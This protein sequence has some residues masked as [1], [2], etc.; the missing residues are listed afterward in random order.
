[1]VEI[2]QEKFI[3]LLA[4]QHILTG[5]H[6][7]DSQ[8]LKEKELKLKECNKR[9]VYIENLTKAEIATEQEMI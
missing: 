1:M 7:I 3:D 9:G 5:D 8:I 4:M 2:Y 6:L